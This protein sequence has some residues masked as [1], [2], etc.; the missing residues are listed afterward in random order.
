MTTPRTK[1]RS[2]G[3]FALLS[4]R[5][6]TP[7]G[8]RAAAVVVDGGRI[9]AV[10]DREAAPAGVPVEDLGD[11]FI[12]PGQVDAHVHINEPGRTDCR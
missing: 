3:E 10:V 8:V 9:A 1:P 5:V 2:S 11:L 6:V 7:A 4:S 12:S